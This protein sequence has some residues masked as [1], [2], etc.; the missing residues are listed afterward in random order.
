MISRSYGI[1][2]VYG[3]TK[4]KVFIQLSLI[5]SASHGLCSQLPALRCHRTR[6]HHSRSRKSLRSGYCHGSNPKKFQG[7]A[8]LSLRFRWLTHR[9]RTL[10]FSQTF[11]K[12]MTFPDGIVYPSTPRASSTFSCS[13]STSYL[14][15]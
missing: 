14:I 9:D 12:T 10:L 15:F 13:S 11:W 7:F 3:P 5:L 6:L 8:F 2:C 4:S 1:S